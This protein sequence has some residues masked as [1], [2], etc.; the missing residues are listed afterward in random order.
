MHIF[1]GIMEKNKG[2]RKYR[3]ILLNDE[4]FEER[5]N[6]RLSKLRM[7][8]LLLLGS[9]FWILLM[10]YLFIYSPLRSYITD[11]KAQ[12]QL[13]QQAL[14]LQQQIDSLQK[15]M[16]HNAF[17]IKNIQQI[18]AGEYP[19]QIPTDTLVPDSSKHNYEHIADI[20]NSDD[21]LL[22]TE[23]ERANSLGIYYQEGEDE[24][25][26][27]F[28]HRPSVLFPPLKG[29]YI[30]RYFNASKGHYGIDIVAQKNDPI[31]SIADGVVII[32]QWTIENGYVI[33]IQHANNTVSTYKHNAALLKNEGDYVK[34]GDLIA[35]IGNSGTQSSG[36][37]LHFELWINSVAVNPLDYISFE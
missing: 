5:F 26:N 27:R 9:L 14:Q 37:H 16:A 31:K 36:T 30:T 15:K 20:R 3:L 25:S 10:S 6:L 28:S 19:G 29:G 8:F 11:D 24:F 17:Y 13:Q 22:R 18:M 32:A 33:G 23:M 4:S 1:A 12:M 7:L 35:I 2:K 34:T 21:S